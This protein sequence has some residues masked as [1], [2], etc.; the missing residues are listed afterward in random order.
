[1]ADDK[2]KTGRQDR[3]R[4]AGGQDY[5]VEDFHQKHKHLT[6]EQARQ[7]ITQARG[8]RAKADEIAERLKGV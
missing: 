3:I 2:S 4:V 7:I 1:M 8:N 5:E 6:L